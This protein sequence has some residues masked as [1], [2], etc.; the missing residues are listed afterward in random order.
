MVLE[1]FLWS[2]TLSPNKE[3]QNDPQY[4]PVIP[5]RLIN[6]S[7]FNVDKFSKARRLIEQ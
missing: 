6:G 2:D 4:K 3:Q 1:P 5:I 7:N